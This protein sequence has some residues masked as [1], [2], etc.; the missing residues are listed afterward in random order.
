MCPENEASTRK[1]IFSLFRKFL[2]SSRDYY[3]QFELKWLKNAWFN[4]SLPVSFVKE[5]IDNFL[6]VPS[7]T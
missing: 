4:I 6:D 5:K 1:F 2:V 3:F 7:F